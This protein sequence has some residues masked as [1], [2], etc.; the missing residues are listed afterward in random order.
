MFVRGV[1]MVVERS[2]PLG[3][4]GGIS[5]DCRMCRGLWLSL[6]GLPSGERWDNAVRGLQMRMGGSGSNVRRHRRIETPCTEW[7]CD[8]YE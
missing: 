3:G 8:D 7:L 5:R 6:G 2:V 1:G 4:G